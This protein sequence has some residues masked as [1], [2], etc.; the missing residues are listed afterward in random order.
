MVDISLTLNDNDEEWYQLNLKAIDLITDASIAL[1]SEV[2]GDNPE[3]QHV[4]ENEDK[5]LKESSGNYIRCSFII[6]MFNPFN[7]KF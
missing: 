2:D 4:K 3:I 7:N 1:I 5:R 6:Q